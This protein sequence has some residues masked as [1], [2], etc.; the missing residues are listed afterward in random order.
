MPVEYNNGKLTI[1]YGT[2]IECPQCLHKYKTRRATTPNPKQG[3]RC[4]SCKGRKAYIDGKQ[5]SDWLPGFMKADT[6]KRFS[7]MPS[8]QEAEQKK[9]IVAATE[10]QE[11]LR[12]LESGEIEPTPLFGECAPVADLPL[13]SPAEIEKEITKHNPRITPQPAAETRLTDIADV[14]AQRP[15]TGSPKVS[16][17]ML[18]LMANNLAMT[19]T[20]L[21]NE[22]AKYQKMPDE[23]VAELANFWVI[24][25][26]ELKDY[27]EEHKWILW[28]TLAL[29]HLRFLM[30]ALEIRRTGDAELKKKTDAPQTGG[31]VDGE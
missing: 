6:N 18:G 29:S 31:V 2:E 16:N 26:D 25:L 9:E 3:Y 13:M 22:L 10:A 4:S 28:G 20:W 14:A 8:P 11:V 19:E 1:L 27:I 24:M 30:L 15:K 12:K 17:K 5:Y 21:L 23:A 7:D